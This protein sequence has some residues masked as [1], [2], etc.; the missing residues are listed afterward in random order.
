MQGIRQITLAIS[1][2]VMLLQPASAFRSPNENLEAI[3]AP[4]ERA[5]GLQI[6]PS[7]PGKPCG[8]DGKFCDVMAGEIIIQVYGRGIVELLIT[9]QEA[10]STY[11]KACA[12]AFEGLSGSAPEFADEIIAEAFNL[13]ATQG[14]FKRVIAG[15][16]VSVRPDTS[17]ILGCK[18]FRY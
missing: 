15:V 2:L 12:G 16:E 1:I 4:I 17:G 13:A 8:D 18:F 7:I 10:P 14:K 11:R 6:E 9:P 5:T 3:S